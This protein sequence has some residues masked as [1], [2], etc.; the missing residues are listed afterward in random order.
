MPY[1]ITYKN[2]DVTYQPQENEADH[3]AI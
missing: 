3:A 2:V 1:N